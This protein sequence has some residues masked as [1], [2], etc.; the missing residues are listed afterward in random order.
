MHPKLAG[1]CLLNYSNWLQKKIDK[2]YNLPVMVKSEPP[3]AHST[4]ELVWFLE[5]HLLYIYLY[6]LKYILNSSFH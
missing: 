6:I 4:P 2:R 5:H 1:K 3:K